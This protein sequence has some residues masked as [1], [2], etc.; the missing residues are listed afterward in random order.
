MMG[1]C[2]SRLRKKRLYVFEK[3]QKSLLEYMNAMNVPKMEIFLYR[4]G[5]NFGFSLK[6][7]APGGT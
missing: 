2:L 3:G 4:E 7:L 5:R 1:L 6:V